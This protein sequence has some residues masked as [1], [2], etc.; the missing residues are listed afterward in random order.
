MS[1]SLFMIQLVK[2]VGHNLKICMLSPYLYYEHKKIYNVDIVMICIYEF[3]MG[4]YCRS[5]VVTVKWKEKYTFLQLRK[6]THFY[7]YPFFVT[8]QY[9]KTLS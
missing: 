7:S 8:L 1:F 3:H 2:V 6:N 9:K 5:L 4:A